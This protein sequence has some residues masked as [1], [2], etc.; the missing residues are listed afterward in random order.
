MGVLANQTSQERDRAQTEVYFYTGSFTHTFY[1]EQFLYPPKGFRYLPSSDDLMSSA[2]KKDIAR[3]TKWYDPSLRRFEGVVLRTVAAARLPKMRM[4][5]APKCALIHSAQYPLLNQT[6]WV[7]DFEDVSAFTWYRRDVLDS[8]VARGFLERI[9][10]SP[11]CRGIL[12]WTDAARKSLENG[13]DCSRFRDKIKVV[14]PTITPREDIELI[15]REK[16]AQEKIKILFVGTAFYAKGGVEALVVLDELSRHYPI[17]CQIVSNVPE[18]YRKKYASNPAIQ[19]SSRISPDELS[20]HFRTS[21]LFFAPYHTDTFGFAV[22][23]GFSHGLPCVATSQFALPEI[24]EDGVEGKIVKNSQSRF[25]EKC[26]P[27]KRFDNGLDQMIQELREPM[28]D[29]LNQLKEAIAYMIENRQRLGSFGREAYQAV[30]MGRFSPQSRREV[31]SPIYRV[32]I[33]EPSKFTK[34][35]LR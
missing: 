11:Y 31:L 20:Q 29:Y 23:E 7:I 6:P 21:H 33:D 25:D 10:A 27:Q 5:K 4:I 32:A 8:K 13:L 24:V 19:F 3:S 12:P 2:M 14:A 1:K 15:W 17:V 26:L 30:S 9:F 22:L 35:T 18:E 34:G 28:R 16:N